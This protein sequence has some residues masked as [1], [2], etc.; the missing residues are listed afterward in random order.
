MALSR[1]SHRCTET[2]KT[3]LVTVARV[4]KTT[5]ASTWAAGHGTTALS[6]IP[7]NTSGPVVAY[8]RG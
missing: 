5:A 3:V 6:T 7:P 1:S 2:A 4:K 8:P